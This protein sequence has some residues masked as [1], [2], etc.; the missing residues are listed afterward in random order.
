MHTNCDPPQSWILIAKWSAFRVSRNYSSHKSNCRLIGMNLDLNACDSP[1]QLRLTL[2]HLEYKLDME[3]H[4]TIKV[5]ISM[6]PNCDPPQSWTVIA[7]YVGFPCVSQLQLRG[8]I[9][10]DFRKNLG[11]WPHPRAP[12][13]PPRKLGRQKKKKKFNVYFAF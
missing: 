12:P 5:T 1:K 3:K 9:K 11:F 4:K 7:K 13:P 6:H 2:Q 8:A 10:I